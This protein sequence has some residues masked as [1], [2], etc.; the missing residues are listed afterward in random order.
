MLKKVELLT[1]QTLQKNEVFPGQSRIC[2]SC[3]KSQKIAKY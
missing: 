3:D 2:S 1:L